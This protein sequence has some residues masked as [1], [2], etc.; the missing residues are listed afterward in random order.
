M[1]TLRITQQEYENLRNSGMSKEQILSKY[2]SDSPGILTRAAEAVTNFVGARGIAEQFGADIARTG[3]LNQ[4][5]VQA[6]N[7]VE[8][9]SMRKVVGSAIQTGANF[10]PGLGAGASLPAK[11]LTGAATGYVYDVGANL[12]LERKGADAFKPG[13]GT[14]AGGALPIIGAVVGWASKGATQWGARKLEEIN[15]RLTPTER[16]NLVR[17]GKDIAEYLAQKKVIGTPAQRYAKVGNLYNQMENRVQDVI[18]KSGATFVDNAGTISQPA[19]DFVLDLSKGTKNV[20]AGKIVGSGIPRVSMVTFPKND[21]LADLSRI[22]DSFLDDPEAAAEAARMV[23]NLQKYIQTNYADDVEAITINNL[24]RNY[25]NRAFAKNAT[26]VVSDT[27][28][29]VGA[30]FNKML[31]DNI[32]DLEPLNKEYGYIIA[33]RRAMQKALTRPQIGLTGKLIGIA[34]GSFLGNAIGG[35]V[36]AAGGAAIGPTVGKVVA[37]TPVRSTVG[38]GLQILSDSI[39]KLPT[40]RLGNVSHKAVL[41]LLEGLKQQ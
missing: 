21:V 16:Q 39:K 1:A 10:I 20:N 24:K 30:T 32:P 2:S 27:R 23:E 29:A 9:P 8:Y 19:S 14:V 13:I 17:Q 33:S 15:L 22:P 41:N 37:G 34:S 36:G 7:Q 40:D 25:M 31:R 18:K 28:L 12:Q 35:P 6:A 4:G 11:I 38:A 3:L 5:N 26:D